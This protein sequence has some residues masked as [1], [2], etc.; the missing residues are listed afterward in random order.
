V[1]DCA[2]FTRKTGVQLAN[3]DS[4][5]DPNSLLRRSNRTVSNAN[6]TC[7]FGSP[8]EVGR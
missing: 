3:P 8:D 2:R 6:F 7:F 5:R 4:Y 1:L